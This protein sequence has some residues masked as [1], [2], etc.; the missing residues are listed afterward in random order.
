MITTKQML[1]NPSGKYSA[2][3]SRRDLIIENLKNRFANIYEKYGDFEISIYKEGEDIY[4]YLKVPSETVENFYFD[5]VIEATPLSPSSKTDYTINNYYLKLFSNSPNFVFTYTY[6]YEQT[7]SLIDFLKDKIDEKA[8]TE[9]PKVRNPIQSYGFEKSVYFA[10][11]FINLKKLDKKS[12]LKY[13]TLNKDELYKKIATSK[14][15]LKKYTIEHRKQSLQKKENKKRNK[16][17]AMIK[18]KSHFIKKR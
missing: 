9:P 12:N 15:T 11:L 3:F 16:K 8:L 18:T 7:N 4:Y 13:E 10:L 5:V 14:S 1:Q 6:V 17:H 2:Y